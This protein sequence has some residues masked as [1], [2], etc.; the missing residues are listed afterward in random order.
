[1]NRR[2]FLKALGFGAAA[3]VAPVS[4]A[5][6][7]VLPLELPALVAYPHFNPALQYGDYITICSMDWNEQELIRLAKEHLDPGV[8]KCVPPQH[9]DKVEWCVTHPTP[10]RSDPLGQYGYVG[11]KY[12]P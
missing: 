5:K 11:W 4:L 12:Q 2:D 3:L 10:S 1:M 6:Q 7:V 9:R 8:V